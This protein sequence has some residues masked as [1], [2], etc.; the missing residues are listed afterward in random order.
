MNIN[1]K[2]KYLKYKTKYLNGGNDE[3]KCQ[4]YI[5]VIEENKQIINKF[6]EI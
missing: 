4:K 2:Y 5:Q 6:K 3:D 1:N